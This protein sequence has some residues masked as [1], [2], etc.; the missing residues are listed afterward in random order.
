MD[1]PER[2]PEQFEEDAYTAVREAKRQ[3]AL[4]VAI[5]MALTTHG[6]LDEMLA[7]CTQ[8]LV[9]H[10]GAAFARIW[11]LNEETQMLELKA[12]A[13]I[14][15]HLNGGH[16]RVPVGKLKIGRI[17]AV[18]EP[19]LTNDVQNDPH[20]ADK[21]WAAREGMV[22]F[23]GYP[24]LVEKRI[25][26]VMAMFA[27]QPIPESVLQ[28]LSSIAGLVAQSIERK[29]IDA[30]RNLWLARE[31]EAR[32]EAEV[33]N[34]RL[35]DLFMQAPASICV[36][37]GPEHIYELA[38]PLY[39]RM[40]GTGRD[41]LGKPIREALPELENQGFYELLD[42]VYTTGEAFIGKEARVSIDRNGDGI[43]EDV[44]VD[45]VYQ[46]R[47]NADGKVDGVI[48]HAIDVTEQ[49]HGRE[50][51][52]KSQERLLEFTNRLEALVEQRTEAL[53]QTMGTLQITNTELQRS[54]QELQDFAY[55]ASHDLQEPL[56]KIQAFGNLLEEEYGSVLGEGKMY[57]NRMRD[58][59]SRMR[60]LINDLLTF[61]RVTTKA[62]PFS[63]VDLTAV[64][65][66]VLGDLEPRL[67]ASQGT[68]QVGDLPTIEAD[69]QQMYQ[70]FQNLLS[71]ALKFHK[72]DVPPEVKVYAEISSSEQ[73]CQ[74]FVEDN[75]IGF[76]EKYLDRIF[77]VFQR[78][79][80]KGKYE[81]TGVGLAVVR[82]IV[83]RHGGSV[84]A[85]TSNGNGATFIV[86]LPF[87]P[88]PFG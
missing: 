83:E 77:T 72:P 3:V 80:G 74:L 82:K 57:L 29:Y 49:V 73:R 26:G 9:E 59:A 30:E 7:H 58:A 54:N 69:P 51:L 5:S 43:L 62:Q 79:H 45:F 8:L 70:V 56:R 21:A 20:I 6:T 4:V 55:V 35:L 39:L 11:T 68:I 78:L 86:T 60:N 87:T 12:S 16:S 33:V 23:A 34:Q 13:G 81:G 10:L 19:H 47:R 48:V 37:R 40:I 46:P 25:V 28:E 1:M 2:T 52:K 36:F 63:P 31:Q 66:D 17:A 38:N 85:K 18:R 44:F 64:L 24:L 88:I 42:Q 50:A 53:R 61:S 65:Q 22:A 41:I 27:R 84:T 15:T 14:Y 75:G 32:V 71:N 76:D 67:Q